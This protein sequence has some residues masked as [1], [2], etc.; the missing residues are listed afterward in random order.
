MTKH[1]SVRIGGSINNAVTAVLSTIDIIRSN[2]T[3]T[4][5]TARKNG[6]IVNTRMQVIFDMKFDDP[7]KQSIHEIIMAHG[8]AAE[9]LGPGGFDMCI[10]LLLEK[11]VSLTKRSQQ[12]TQK[13]SSG[14]SECHGADYPTRIDVEQIINEYMAAAPPVV[15]HILTTALDLA[16]FGGRIVIEKT[17]VEPSVELVRGYTFDVEPAWMLTT[18]LNTPRVAVVDG[19][20]ESV[21][22]L[23]H[24]LESASESNEH[25]LLFIRGMSDD[26][27][28]TLKV[29]Y[30]RRTLKVIPMIV[31]FDLQGINTV[32]DVAIVSGA[33]LVSSVKGD[34]ISNMVMND[35]QYVDNALIYPNK[36]V[37]TNARTHAA[38]NTHVSNLRK[39][40]NDEKID[41]VA[42]LIDVRIRSLSPNHVVI[43]LRDD[44]DF[45]ITSQAIDYTLR[46]FRSLVDNGTKQHISK[47][48]LATTLFAANIHSERCF[49]TLT[50]MGA[51]IMQDSSKHQD[52]RVEQQVC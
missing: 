34:L 30:D 8:L 19:Y 39:K 38:V 33:D 31:K 29:N 21:S 36:I 49:E 16:G 13:D 1:E 24:F 9:Q 48:V 28:H 42:Q 14:Q 50:S 46:A 20:I 25:V 27:K 12:Q 10:E 6:F 41:D 4:A 17:E 52:Q 18:R 23:H 37:I 11:H 47:R 7:L 2:V 22:E 51:V 3:S 5:L 15:R 26:V 35:L 44:K 32:N 43:R 40:R 45:V